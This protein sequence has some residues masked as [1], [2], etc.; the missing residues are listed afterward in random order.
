[1][2]KQYSPFQK[3]RRE[4]WKMK[5][6]KLSCV[7]CVQIRSG[8]CIHTYSEPNS[9][10]LVFFCLFIVF[11]PHFFFSKKHKIWIQ[12]VVTNNLLGGRHE[13][14]VLF[15]QYEY[16]FLTPQSPLSSWYHD[17]ITIKIIMKCLMVEMKKRWSLQ[18]LPI[19]IN[20]CVHT[21][22]EK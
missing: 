19:F 14:F 5:N 3:W 16:Y 18:L 20:M 21:S 2:G 15:K 22:M 9:L 11:F 6:E 4:F 7:P 8:E 12:T 1:M 10:L 17:F 13:V